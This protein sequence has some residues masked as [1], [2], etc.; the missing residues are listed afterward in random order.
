MHILQNRAHN[1]FM[2]ER[3]VTEATLTLPQTFGCKFTE[4]G[5]VSK[6]F[7]LVSLISVLRM[8][9]TTGNFLR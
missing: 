3:L 7:I 5:D 4:H 9:A 6:W 1:S 2:H 8:V